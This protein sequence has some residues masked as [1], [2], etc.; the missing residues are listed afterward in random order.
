MAKKA[1]KEKAEVAVSQKAE[2]V[3]LP[4]MNMQE[5]ITKAIEQGSALEVLDRLCGMRD[6]LKVEVAREAY[7]GDLARFQSECPIIKKAKQVKDKSG[8]PRYKYAPLEVIVEAVR[9]PL[10]KHGFSYTIQT[11]QS[12]GSVT[13][14]C[15]AHHAGGHSESSTF[16]I[17]IDKDAYMND[18]QKTA[19]AMTYAKR[20][21]FCNAF[22]IMTGD[23]DDDARGTDPA[24][25]SGSD[26]QTESKAQPQQNS[27][28]GSSQSAKPAEQPAEKPKGRTTEEHIV[29]IKAHFKLFSDAYGEEQ[30]SAE[31]LGV[32]EFEATDRKTGEKTGEIIAGYTTPEGLEEKAREK[33]F[34]KTARRVQ[35][36]CHKFENAWKAALKKEE[37]ADNIP[38]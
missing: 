36:V 13:A 24:H 23:E 12:E 29:S 28:A 2:I 3:M 16:T 26:T 17:P 11:E 1:K 30:A 25:A 15:I 14:T 4:Q 7:F 6:R 38:F 8:K 18:A 37:D 33:G 5:L 21:S 19:S 20:Y 9:E 31:L 32:T 27:P 10:E 34:D 22:G 35:V